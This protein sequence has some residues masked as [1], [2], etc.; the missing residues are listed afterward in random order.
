[1]SV[2]EQELNDLLKRMQE[3]YQDQSF[4]NG[5]D[6]LVLTSI[7]NDIFLPKENEYVGNPEAIVAFEKLW[8]T[9]FI[10]WKDSLETS[11]V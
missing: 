1:M 9:S 11:L 7:W 10:G 6:Q 2:T 3:K 8:Y 5:N 4:N